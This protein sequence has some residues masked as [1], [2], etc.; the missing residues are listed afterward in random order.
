MVHGCNTMWKIKNQPS[1]STS[2]SDNVL[3]L[4][5]LVVGKLYWGLQV[6]SSFSIWGCILKG[7]FERGTFWRAKLQL[8][9]IEDFNLE[10]CIQ[11]MQNQWTDAWIKREG[12]N[13]ACEH[14]GNSS[15]GESGTRLA[16]TSVGLVMPFFYTIWRIMMKDST[17][18][19]T[20]RVCCVQVC[21]VHMHFNVK[22]FKIITL[23]SNF[24]TFLQHFTQKKTR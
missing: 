7:C 17:F 6:T 21:S 9:G 13:I 11:D 15:W 16:Q 10:H 5:V 24:Q 1:N 14:V 2:C 12:T 22:G 20:C 4:L 18:L 3:R 8:K 23:H 19:D